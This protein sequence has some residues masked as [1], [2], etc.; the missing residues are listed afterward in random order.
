MP[1]KI[2][3]LHNLTL[4]VYGKLSASKN[5]KF[6]PKDLNQR[7]L[8]FIDFVNCTNIEI[9]GGGKIDGR[10]Y[11]WWVL[12][13]VDNKKYLKYDDRPIL[14]HMEFSQFIKIHDLLFKNSAQMT[15]KMDH[16]YDV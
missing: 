16:C 5:V 4:S 11:H 9:N 14:L 1:I 12:M 7:N 3:N 6:W 10:G 15:I 2:I 13:F 8:H